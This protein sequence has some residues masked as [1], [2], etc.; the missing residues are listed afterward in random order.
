MK[1]LSAVAFTT[2]S[3]IGYTTGLIVA[4]MLLVIL[5]CLIKLDRIRAQTA[6]DKAIR[7]L[8]KIEI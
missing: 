7:D 4:V 2:P 1:S 6:Q 8:D 3:P 5:W